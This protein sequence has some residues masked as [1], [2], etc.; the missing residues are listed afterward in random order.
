MQ[1][2]PK[3]LLAGCICAMIFCASPVLAQDGQAAPCEQGITSV[4]Q[5]RLWDGPVPGMADWAGVLDVPIEESSTPDGNNLF[6]VT[7][8]TL[9][10]FL[11]HPGC[12]TGASVL[13]V[14][15]GGFRLVAINHEGRE[16]GRWLARRGIAAFVLKYRTVQYGEP[17]LTQ[18][19]R[20]QL[21][22]TVMAQAA[23]EDAYRAMDIIRSRAGQY[24]IDPERIGALGFS[25]GGHVVSMLSLDPDVAT[26]PAF[27]GVIYGALFTDDFPA[28][29]PANLPPGRDEPEEP[30][31]R[32]PPTPAPGRL[33]P[34]FL[35]IAQDDVTVMLGFRTFYDRLY[36]SGYRPETHLYARGGHGFGMTAQGLTS[37]RWIDQFHGWLHVQ[38]MILVNAR[39]FHGEQ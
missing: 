9:E 39:D 26:R 6:N 17:S 20:R 29:P 12:A 31:L 16:V 38:G 21:P 25:A 15:G 2:C 1:I 28:L 14:P 7:D 8:P 5:E 22:M 3:R 27:T 23:M 11:P 18:P 4:G 37:D 32:G 10:A 30:W 34:L 35:A 13:V 33:P 24:G 36:E 19:E